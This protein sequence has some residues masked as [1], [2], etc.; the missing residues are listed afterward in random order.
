MKPKT[1]ILM[2]VAVGCGL[3]ASFMTSRY[4]AA[5][6]GTP[7]QD[8]E[9]Q[10]LIAVKK[11]SGYTIM[12]DPTVFEVKQMKRSEVNKD[13]VGEFS[14]IKGH[15][16]KNDL[17]AGKPLT[18]S[19][20]ID[21]S[22]AGLDPK[23]EKG[24]VA[25]TVKATSDK[26]AAGFILPGRRVDVIAYVSRG[27]DD[28]P[29]AK[30]ILQNKEV[31]AINHEM[32]APP[33][34]V[35]KQAERVT[36]RLKH[37]EAEI[38]SVYQGSGT[39]DLVLRRQDDNTIYDTGEG[40]HVEGSKRRK[41]GSDPVGTPETTTPTPALTAPAVPE[42]KPAVVEQPKTEEKSKGP[43]TLEVYVG[44]QKTTTVFPEAE[45]KDKAKENKD[46]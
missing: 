36:L 32:E 37:Q 16:L 13:A 24:E 2:L 4:L 17:D 41:G 9:V 46:K 1:L 43:H 20:L 26:S 6:Q 38:L 12:K 28:G 44:G 14:R 34:T 8:E 19:D 11:L 25:M 40:A 29:F 35:N 15:V 39:L 42:S 3:A 45:A 18:E 33:G 23:L 21:P 5:Q 22:A 30:T 10:V 31:L 27:G 7:Q